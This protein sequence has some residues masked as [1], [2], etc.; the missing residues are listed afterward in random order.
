LNWNKAP[1]L[2][3]RITDPVTG[4]VFVA[5][6]AFTVL[7]F[8]LRSRS[9]VALSVGVFLACGMTVLG[10]F[11]LAS[12]VF[13][14]TRQ[15]YHVRV[16]VL[17]GDHL[18]VSDADVTS[19]SG[20]EPKAVKGGWEFDIPPQAKPLSGQLVLFAAEPSSFLSG[21]ANVTLSDDYFPTVTIQL[22]PDRSA[23]VRGTVV[24]ERGHPVAGADVSVSGYP[25][26]VVTDNMGSFS[27]YAH[28]A[29]GQVVSLRAQKSDLTASKSVPTGNTPVELVLRRR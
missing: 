9:R 26:I 25:E 3:S 1:E 4:A 22:V 20:G 5:A 14:Q 19:S 21:Q 16:T 15:V 27:V 13:L 28:A 17:G 2:A 11:P 23:L 24:D 12:S 18:P 29:D 10:L 8:A 6:M 7:I